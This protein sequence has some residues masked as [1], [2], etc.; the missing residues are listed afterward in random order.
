MV[1]VVQPQCM[2][3]ENSINLH[4]KA[5]NTRTRTYS[6]GWRAS[7]LTRYQ[8]WHWGLVK[9]PDYKSSTNLL[10]TDTFRIL[11]TLLEQGKYRRVM[12][13]C[14][15]P[16]RIM[17]LLA[18]VF[19][20]VRKIISAKDK[21]EAGKIALLIRKINV[22]AIQGCHSCYHNWMLPFLTIFYWSVF[23]IWIK[24][25]VVNINKW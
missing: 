16:I 20:F 18:L 6:F 8:V 10:D 12:M 22:P 11:L 3:I 19:Y 24:L 14:R 23:E 17:V 15:R 25:W 1:R 9:P 2:K 7:N 13:D 5:N 21:L 4:P